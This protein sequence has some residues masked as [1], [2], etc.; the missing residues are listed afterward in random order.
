M[1]LPTE[2]ER[3]SRAVLRQAAG[4][5][6]SAL[7]ALYVS[8]P[9]WHKDIFETQGH[10]LAV[11]VR[12]VHEYKLALRE[13]Q[14][15][16]LVAP[17]M[18]GSSRLPL[19]QYY[20][21]TGYVLPGLLCWAGLDPY[22]S[23]KAA[24]VLMSLVGAFGVRKL[25]GFLGCDAFAAFT[26]S[27][28]FQLFPFGGID[29]INRGA[30]IEWASLQFLPVTMW[31]SLRTLASR[32]PA[33]TW[34]VVVT[35]SLGWAF[36]V[37]IHPVQT[38]YAGGLSAVLVMW[39]GLVSLRDRGSVGRAALSYLF[40]T[41]LS[42]WYWLPILLDFNAIQNAA[43][44]GLYDTGF[45]WRTLLAPCLVTSPEVV[46][47]WAVQVGLHFV[48]A[49]LVVLLY[50][51]SYRRFTWVASLCFLACLLILLD[52]YRLK[53]VHSLFRPMQFTY[54]LLIPAA[55]AGVLCL[56][57][58]LAVLKA[59][60]PPRLGL[61][62]RGLFLA[63]VLGSS[64]L[65]FLPGYVG[66]AG[67]NYPDSV[68]KILAPDYVSVNSS[69]YALYG[70]DYREL[71]W[72]D[73][74][75]LLVN[76]EHR[77]PWEGVPF[78]FRLVAECDR[79]LGGMSFLV[80]NRRQLL[81][82]SRAG[83][84]RWSVRGLVLPTRGMCRKLQA[85]RFEAPC[86]ADAIRVSDFLVRPVG[87]N[88]QWTRLPL[89]VSQSKVGRARYYCVDVE[90]GKAGLY[91]LPIHYYSALRVYVNGL[92]IEMSSA[93]RSMVIV[94]LKEGCNVIRVATLPNRV[95]LALMAL[96]SGT[97]LGWLG[98]LPLRRGREAR[99]PLGHEGP[100]GGIW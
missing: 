6:A 39:H 94:P 41:L 55:L 49:A 27:V 75:H 92:R 81:M 23:L 62:L 4:W 58:F 12:H 80:D 34:A 93:D 47:G 90:A 61:A 95:A 24:I 33:G 87:D 69:Q 91:Q 60:L 67:R 43:H 72:I 89:H 45:T 66:V 85:V 71:G 3:P 19:F 86:E 1:S 13:G 22:L 28:A 11:H 59:A 96:V 73:R 48:I 9:T 42:A 77:L 52:G 78:E 36:F 99:F 29:L 10:D 21:G 83:G 70:T 88:Q 35:A 82:V 84:N 44:Q 57:E 17:S 54:R 64:C 31:L 7:L 25:C 16:P 26:A 37:P 56:G 97:W 51:P 63:Y 32:S 2:P 74:K 40:G 30:Y 5:F 76:R 65:Y 14:T 20:S 79:D 98:W 68:V 18:N 38:L 46:H 50:R 8:S 53:G 15:I 100:R